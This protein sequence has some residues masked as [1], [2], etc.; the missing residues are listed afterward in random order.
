VVFNDGTIPREL[1]FE[2]WHEA[3][4]PVFDCTPLKDTRELTVEYE[5]YLVD[6]L[7]F[8]TVRFDEQFFSRDASHIDDGAND[9]L[10]VQFYKRGSIRGEVEGHDLLMQPDRISIQDFACSYSGTSE[11]STSLGVL[12]P[13]HLIHCHDRIH[14]DKPVFSWALN[15]PQGRLLRHALESIWASLPETKAHEAPAMAAGFVGLL[16]GLLSAEISREEKAALRTASFAAVRDYIQSNMHRPD[17]SVTEICGAFNCSRPTLYRLFHEY[18]GVQSYIRDQRLNRCFHELVRNRYTK[19]RIGR[20]A[21]QWG[22]SDPAHF[23]RLFRKTYGTS[24]SAMA[25]CASAEHAAKKE[26]SFVSEDSARLNSW[27]LNL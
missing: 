8:N 16:N 10:S 5:G 15:S 23:S 11:S 13:R 3:L 24:P 14:K 9:C 27:L 20:I 7:I 26:G 2:A 6:N 18:G 22:F 4:R 17:L 19:K 21:E 1:Q 12:I 25:G